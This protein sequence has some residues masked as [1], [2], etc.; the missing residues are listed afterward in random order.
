MSTNKT[1]EN[2]TRDLYEEGLSPDSYLDPHYEFD[3]GCD[4]G[5]RREVV[6]KSN[7][8]QATLWM[9]DEYPLNLHVILKYKKKLVIIS[10]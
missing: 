4:I 1:D 2:T 10:F 3:T 9:A 7:A 8:F 5:K 6:K